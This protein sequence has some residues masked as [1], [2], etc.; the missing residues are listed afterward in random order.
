[1][2][3]TLAAFGLERIRTGTEEIA[4]AAHG[5]NQ[6]AAA[7]ELLPQVANVHVEC[8]IETRGAAAVE[9]GHELVSGNDAAGRVYK[10]LEDLVFDGGE[11][12]RRPFQEGFA[13]RGDERDSSSLK[14]LGFLDRASGSIRAA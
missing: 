9:T 13:R 2:E 1:M 14:N 6:S 3:R 8:A 7:A 10:E 12:K 11:G 5:S 4:H